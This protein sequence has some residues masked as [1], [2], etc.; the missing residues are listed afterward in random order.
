MSLSSIHSMTLLVL[1]SRLFIRSLTVSA[2]AV[3]VL[4]SAK[5]CKSEPSKKNMSF[6]NMLKNI[7]SSIDPCGMSDRINF[8]MLKLFL[9]LTHYLCPLKY[10]SISFRVLVSKPYSSSFATNKSWH[11][12]LKAFDRSIR[13]VPTIL[14]SSRHLRHVSSILKRTC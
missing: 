13:G 1:T 9:I 11:K 14:F 8:K 6:M 7:G 2:T 4:S 3:T 10:D 12:Q 5:L